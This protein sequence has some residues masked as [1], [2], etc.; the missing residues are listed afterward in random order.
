MK[1]QN[2]VLPL[3]SIEREVERPISDLT[4]RQMEERNDETKSQRQRNYD[5]Q[6]KVN[7]G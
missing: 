5:S 7:D 6:A 2:W 3:L 4:Q 1:Q